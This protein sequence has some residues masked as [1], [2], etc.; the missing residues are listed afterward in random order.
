MEMEG[1]TR[2][3]SYLLGQNLS[4]GTLITVRHRAIRKWI[5]TAPPTTNTCLMCGIQQRVCTWQAYM[6]MFT[7]TM[8]IQG[9][10]LY[11]HTSLSL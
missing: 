6:H 4:T 5:T 8:Y 2:S 10:P 7:S 3:R 11:F 1:F 9:L